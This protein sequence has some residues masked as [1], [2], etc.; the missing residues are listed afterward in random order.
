M[1]TMRLATLDANLLVA[2]DVFLEELHIT[3]AAKRLGVSQPAAS[4]MLQRLRDALDDP[5]LVRSGAGMA[6]TP[7]AL[8]MA[9]ALKQALQLL[10]RAIYEAAPFDPATA[11]REFRLAMLDIYSL[12]L[13]PHLT[14]CLLAAGPGL[15]LDVQPLLMDQLWEQ[16]RAGLVDAA[17]IGSQWSPPQDVSSAP[18]LGERLVSMVRHDHPI[19]QGEVTP[20]RYVQWPHVTFRISGQGDH[21]IDRALAALGLQRRVACRL[22]YFQVAPLLTVDTDVIVNLPRSLASTFAT[23]WPVAS[24]SPPLDLQ[25]YEV[26]L[27]W[28]RFLDA[29]PAHAW[30]RAQILSCPAAAPDEGSGR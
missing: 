9:P 15:S 29:D 13:I 14:A 7:R 23:R 11:T 8:A 1:P 30:L 27:V 18:F 16:L 2:I 10:E 3:R 19:L 26:R 24:F 4:H 22:P 17:L 5:L 12:T 6:L 25:S 21:A 20:A 28:P